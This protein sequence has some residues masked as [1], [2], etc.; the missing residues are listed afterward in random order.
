LRLIN[1]MTF[2][3]MLLLLCMLPA[4]LQFTH[5]TGTP[6]LVSLALIAALLAVL[7]VRRA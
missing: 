3:C 1:L 5:V 6:R 7:T 4:L 2:V